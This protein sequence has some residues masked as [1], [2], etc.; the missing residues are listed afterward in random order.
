MKPREPSTICLPD[1]EDDESLL[2]LL[3]LQVTVV[4]SFDTVKEECGCGLRSKKKVSL[5]KEEMSACSKVVM[6]VGVTTAVVV[7][8]A[9]GYLL[10]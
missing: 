7:V 3:L 10:L 9:A 5:D 6:V 4:K 8:V 2:L 1:K